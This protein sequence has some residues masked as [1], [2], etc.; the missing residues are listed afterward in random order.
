MARSLGSAIST[1]GLERVASVG[2]LE[3]GLG[4]AQHDLRV[5]RLAALAQYAAQAAVGQGEHAWRSLLGDGD[6]AARQVFGQEQIAVALGLLYLVAQL[7]E[8]DAHLSETSAPSPAPSSPT[9]S[10]AAPRSVVVGR[11]RGQGQQQ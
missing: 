9:A 4:A 10:H 5:R 1:H 6:A 2:R 7:G 11:E 8:L 3:Q